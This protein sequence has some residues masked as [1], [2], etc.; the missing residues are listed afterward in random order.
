MAI[1]RKAEEIADGGSALIFS[2]YFVGREQVN[3]ICQNKRGN[4]VV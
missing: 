3:Q 4:S 1:F 2:I